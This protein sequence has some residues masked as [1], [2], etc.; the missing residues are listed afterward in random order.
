MTGRDNFIQSGLGL[1]FG[2]NR[3]QMP[4]PAKV[5]VNAGLLPIGRQVAV[6][7]V[8]GIDDANPLTSSLKTLTI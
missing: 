6:T 2:I 4:N 8:T 7:N 3:I 1:L 5:V